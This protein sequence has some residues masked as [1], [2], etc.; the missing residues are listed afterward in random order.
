MVT[1]MTKL[2]SKELWHWSPEMS[3]GVEAIDDDHKRLFQLFYEA[4]LIT[5]NKDEEHLLNQLAGNLIL[6]TESHFKREEAIMVASSYPFCDSHFAL[7][8]TITQNLKQRLQQTLEGNGSVADFIVFLKDWFIEHIKGTDQ[9]ISQYTKGYEQKIALALSA[10]GPLTVPKKITIYVVDDEAQQVEMVVELIE[11]GGLSA[12]GFTSAAGFINQP[13]TSHDIVLLDLNMPEMDGIEV[14]R[15][16]HAKGCLPSYVLISGFDEKVLHSTRQF[17][18]AKKM[19]VVSTLTKPLQAYGFIEKIKQIYADKKIILDHSDTSLATATTETEIATILSLAD[20]QHAIEFH[21]FVL[22]YQ[23]QIDLRSGKLHGFEALIRLQHPK[24]GLVFPDQFIALAEQNNLISSITNEVIDMVIQDYSVFRK[25]GINPGIS[26]NISAQ[27]LLDLSIPEQLETKANDAGI[28]PEMITIEL[29]ESA[30][31]T[32]I[33]DS[34]DILN[35]FRMKGFPLSIDDFGTGHSSLVQLYQAPFTELKID[36]R[37]VMRMMDDNEAMSIVKVCI[38]LAKELKMETVAEGVE[39][40]EIW[41]KLKELGCDIAQGY[42]RARP[43]PLKACC[44]WVN[45][46]LN[47]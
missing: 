1:R 23:P 12:Q 34:L 41:N 19:D 45:T 18:D 42:Y 4:H 21:N 10:A 16:L 6:Y 28:P 13:I 2:E 40:E 17:A 22:F 5:H 27:D 33:S 9:Q 29:T 20:L 32:S 15:Y 38:Y 36:Q 47:T 11:A 43:M 30:V 26:I 46:E 24:H 7:H 39:T 37:F 14:M 3:V 44:D 25:A 8:R 35:R 31:L